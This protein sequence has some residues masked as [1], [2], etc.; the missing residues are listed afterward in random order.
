M[1]KNDLRYIKTEEN[2]KQ[3]YLYLL[4]NHNCQHITVK[5]ICAI[6]RCSRNTFY[7]HY[8]TKEA[9]FESVHQEVLDDLADAFVLRTFDANTDDFTANQYYTDGIIEQVAKNKAIIF[10]L[11]AKDDGVF[12]KQFSQT[13]Q[14]KCFESARHIQNPANLERYQL[15]L[16]YL[17]AAITGF[18]FEWR[19]LP[20]LNDQ[21]AKVMLHA[22]HH[23]TIQTCNHI[24]NTPKPY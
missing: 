19:K 4:Q 17:S 21:Q 9:L 5:D 16:A 11:A 6:A 15:Y 8:E 24:L 20:H 14:Q 18:I 1:N 3:A 22:I 2:L 23:Q 12:F 13:I 10:T 7:L